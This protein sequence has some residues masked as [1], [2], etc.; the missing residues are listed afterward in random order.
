MDGPSP[1]SVNNKRHIQS[2]EDMEAATESQHQVADVPLSNTCR[3]AELKDLLKP[4]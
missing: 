2:A 1:D 4:S 3:M